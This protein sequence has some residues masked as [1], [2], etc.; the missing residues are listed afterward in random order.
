MSRTG[1]IRLYYLL[2]LVL[3]VQGVWGLAR[4]IP[5][6]G[7]PFGGFIWHWDLEYQHRVSYSTP[8][9]W[10]GPLAGL[11]PGSTSILS[12]NG[13]PADEYGAV[14][15]ATP[16][17]SSVTYEIVTHDGQQRTVTGPVVR[18]SLG[19][20]LDAYLLTFLTGISLLVCGYLLVGSATT[21]GRALIGFLLLAGADSALFNGHG[22][23]INARYEAWF[24]VALVW[25]PSLPFIGAMLCHFAL[26]Y[27]HPRQLVTR[28]PWLIPMGYSIAGILAS[29]RVFQYLLSHIP[30]LTP[31]A[32]WLNLSQFEHPAQYVSVG[33][34][35]LGG[36]ATLVSCM[37]A[38]RQR[39]QYTQ[40]ERQQIMIVAAAWVLGFIALLGTIGAIGLY[41]PT[42][43]EVFTAMSIM[44]PIGMVYAF[45]N[46]DLIAQL[47][48]RNALQAGLLAELQQV[49]RLKENIQ[50]EVAEHLHNGVLGD[51]K[52]LEMQLYSLHEQTQLDQLDNAQLRAELECLHQQSLGLMRSLRQVVDGAKPVD[53][54]HA[55]LVE[56]VDRL[57]GHLNVP[58][59]TTT[60]QLTTSGSVDDCSPTV[61]TEIYE[62]IRAALNNVR[63]HAQA[64]RCEVKLERRADQIVVA[65]SDDGKGIDTTTSTAPQSP[66]CQL[67]LA[68]IRTR[69]ARMGG[70]LTISA[71][72]PGTLVQVLIPLSSQVIFH[73]PVY[74]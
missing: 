7:Q 61:K 16:V 59:T 4:Q 48:E 35:A 56:T 28:R 45:K 60:Y 72:Q 22:G 71:R 33:Y 31:V 52:A 3:L 65:I 43:L 38:L 58:A 37:L 26:V 53:F 55:G 25:A 47:E 6:L 11:L 69:A 32:S 27:P 23:G 13:R 67:G 50:D 66:H 19:Y 40:A 30:G 24:W 39:R 57:I 15:A 9:N 5:A 63:E 49:H 73:E 51:S 68:S 18:Y 20:L 74:C 46:A 2:A 41:L 36:L 64:T 14:Y 54:R 17:G 12:I 21:T 62:I 29:I 34:M 44:L 8:N 42:R 1:F 10:P 70:Q